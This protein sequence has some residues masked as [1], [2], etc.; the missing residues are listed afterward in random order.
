MT[1]MTVTPSSRTIT[2]RELSRR[3]GEVLNTVATTG[4]PVTVTLGGT[5][6]ATI[7]PVPQRESRIDQMIRQGR[8]RLPRAQRAKGE[9][10]PRLSLPDGVTT[11]QILAD[12]RANSF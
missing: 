1:D 3:T 9:P 5:P 11:D 2:S 8:I 10:L 4:T 7:V 12:D 6:R